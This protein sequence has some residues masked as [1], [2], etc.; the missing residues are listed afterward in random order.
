MPVA[1]V[2]YVVVALLMLTLIPFLRDRR[3]LGPLLL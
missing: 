2:L 1:I 3:Q